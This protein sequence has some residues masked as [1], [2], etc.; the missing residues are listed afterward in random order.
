[1]TESNNKLVI[2]GN[3]DYSAG[4]IDHDGD[5]LIKGDVLPGFSVKATGDIEV[6]GHIQDAEI[7]SGG[8]VTAHA[9]VGGDKGRV[10][11]A[12]SISLLYAENCHLHAGKDLIVADYIINCFSHAE[13][14]VSVVAK[15]GQILG[16]QTYTTHSIQ[17]NIAGSEDGSETL[18]AAGYSSLLQQKM[19]EIEAGQAENL[20]AIGAI[21][22]ALKTLKRII[23]LKKGDTP[24]L[25]EQVE[26][27]QG[28]KTW[29]ES[30]VDKALQEHEATVAKIS[31]SQQASISIFKTIYSGTVIKFPEHKQVIKVNIT[32]LKFQLDEDGIIQTAVSSEPQPE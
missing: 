20:K 5:V 25:R 16:G 24:E 22:K 14:V 10:E 13:G 21:N 18:L 26:E 2:P 29:V 23:I 12:G 8:S 4:N 19:S 1:M 6:T 27:L 15:K 3:I 11:A 31:F 28:M 17:A 32:S 30:K 7:I 9:V